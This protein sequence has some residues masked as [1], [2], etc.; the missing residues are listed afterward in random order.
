M[1]PS[2]QRLPESLSFGSLGPGRWRDEAKAMPQPVPD[3]LIPTQAL[4]RVAAAG[5]NGKR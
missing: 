2:F 4:E 5:G 3:P 1:A